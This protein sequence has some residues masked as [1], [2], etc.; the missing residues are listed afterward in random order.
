M[1]SKFAS[2]LLV[3]LVSEASAAPPFSG[4]WFSCEGTS[5]EFQSLSVERAGNHYKGLLES[6]RNGGVYSAE[7]TGSTR[8]GV[9]KLHGCQSYRGEQSPSCVTVEVTLGT[10]HSSF[11]RISPK[12]FEL[13]IAE[14][15]ARLRES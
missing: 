2:L 7:L 1:R 5:G 14:C 4:Q 3:A 10:R 13:S 9:L 15:H 11:K 12:N 6:S 8:L